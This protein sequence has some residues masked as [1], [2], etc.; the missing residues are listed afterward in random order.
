MSSK[1]EKHI[2]SVEEEQLILEKISKEE[3]Y[4]TILTR[5]QSELRLTKQKLEVFQSE[6]PHQLSFVDRLEEAENEKVSLRKDI[7]EFKQRE[8]RILSDYSDLEEENINLQKQVLQLQREQVRITMY[9]TAV[10]SGYVVHCEKTCIYDIVLCY[11]TQFI[12]CKWLLTLP[13]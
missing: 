9:I 11:M 1:L 6:E 12:S 10:V 3:E 5:L 2:N 7:R 13:S 4:R 8:S